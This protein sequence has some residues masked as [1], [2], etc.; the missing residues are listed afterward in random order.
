MWAKTCERGSQVVKFDRTM[1]LLGVPDSLS[2][3]LTAAV[4]GD[5]ARPLKWVELAVNGRT[6][7]RSA[8][9]GNYA[10]GQ[11]DHAALSSVRWPQRYST[12]RR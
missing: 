10:A 9:G 7:Y 4:K 6:V 8:A 3:L 2:F 11:L 1:Y 12:T 5:G